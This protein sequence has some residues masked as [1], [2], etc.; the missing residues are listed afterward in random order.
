M[1]I[2]SS[3]EDFFQVRKEVKKI[4][5]LEAKQILLEVVMGM[6]L[7]GETFVVIVCTEKR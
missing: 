1:K 2:I 7:C 4:F 6:K 3:L 5:V